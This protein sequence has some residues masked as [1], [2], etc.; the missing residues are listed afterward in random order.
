M[1]CLF[2]K[3][4][5]SKFDELVKKTRHACEDRHPEASENTGFPPSR[6]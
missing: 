3:N 6:E 5:E 1:I 4:V 2:E